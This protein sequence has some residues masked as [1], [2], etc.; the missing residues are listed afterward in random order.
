M[1]M[2]NSKISLSFQIIQSFFIESFSLT[3]VLY[4]GFTF[5]ANRV[6]RYPKKTPGCRPSCQQENA[7]GGGG[8]YID[9]F[10]SS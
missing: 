8:L 10:R 7:S 3:F 4:F 6:R 2:A 1:A 5:A 9:I